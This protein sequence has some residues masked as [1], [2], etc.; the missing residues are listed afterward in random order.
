MP[1]SAAVFAENNLARGLIT[2][3]TGLNFP[4]NACTASSNCIFDWTGEV[5]RRQGIDYETNFA[6]NAF[7]L[8]NQALSTFLWKNVAGD[9]NRNLLVFQCGLLVSFFDIGAAVSPSAGLLASTVTL[10]TVSGA[11]GTANQVECQF[12][13]GGGYLF[14]VHP[15]IDPVSIT[16]TGSGLSA[17]LTATSITIQ[18]RD[19]AGQAEAVAITNRPTTLTT[20]HNY[21][22]LNQG[23]T[24]G[25]HGDVTNTNTITVWHTAESNFP[26][27]A[28]V[29]FL[30]KDATNSF[31]PGGAYNNSSAIATTVAA[32]VIPGNTFAPKGHF[33]GS[34]FNFDPSVVS[35]LSSLTVN[36]SGAARPSTV[37]FFAGRVFYAGVQASG[38][39][40]NI[41]FSNIF[42]QS[43]SNPQSTFG[44]CYQVN[45]PTSEN[46]FDLLPD[47]GGVI[48]VQ[49][50]GTILKLWPMTGG[51]A[52]FATNGIWLITGSV[53]I[54]FTANDYTVRHISSINAISGTSFVDIAGY[55]A[56]WNAEGMY[57]LQGQQLD[58]VSVQSLTNTTIR[59][60]YNTIPL[61]CKRLARGAFNVVTSE[62]WWVYPSQQ[63]VDTT[64]NYH[65]DS[66]LVLNLLTGSFSPWTIPITANYVC[67]INI[68]SNS[69]GLVQETDVVSA[70]SALVQ[71]GSGNQV[72]SF[73]TLNPVVQPTFE[74]L[75]K[76][77]KVGQ[78]QI[79][80]GNIKN[81]LYL[82]WFTDDGVGR[83]AP[84]FFTTGY[85]VH[86]EAVKKFTT[87]YLYLYAD[88]IPSQFTVQAKWNYSLSQ[89]SGKWST[90]QTVTFGGGLPSL[91]P[92]TDAS[93]GTNT[94]S[95]GKYRLKIPGEG[96]ALQFTLASTPGQNFSLIGWS[97]FD[98]ANATP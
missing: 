81:P 72:G 7:T 49:E 80:F 66:V 82:D 59:T 90:A 8:A 86:G 43:Q 50:C 36:T 42:F 95:V 53:G 96:L 20:A 4:E 25:S 32:N 14:V 12:A 18:V 33:I 27:N 31:N 63:P 87:N 21:N 78:I 89:V 9:G 70:A 77:F 74:F 17:T 11:P 19:F 56:W 30:Y 94:Y 45:D 37:G 41:Y 13:S 22:L 97:A 93:T 23:W 58:A 69:G 91:D 3:A 29:W 84:A 6:F 54:G 52:V 39:S 75:V 64:S 10:S 76:V 57:I 44:Q 67:G 51:L 46:E 68:F 83:D 71:D 16:Y 26:S 60:F 24:D 55:P 65:F 88:V 35:G 62:A 47:D 48:V 92:V 15:Y 5:S 2:E 1:R 79:T 98:T 73:T 34:A 38:Y 85:K 61:A 28:D 40:S